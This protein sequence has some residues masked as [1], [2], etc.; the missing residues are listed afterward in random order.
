[1]RQTI[2]Q[3]LP[4]VPLVT[5]RHAKELQAM[6]DIIAELAESVF[7]A[8]DLDL[9]QGARSDRGRGGLAAEQV[10]RMFV[11][12][13]MTQLSYERLSFALEDS[14]SY[15]AFC[16]LGAADG[17]P[18]RSTL[19]D[20]IKRL[21]PETLQKIHQSVVQLG[22]DC[23]LE[24]G[25]RIGIDSTVIET[26][27]H[28]PT[29]SSLLLDGVEKLTSLLN[30]ARAFCSVHFVDHRKRAKRRALAICFAKSNE[31]RLAPYKDLLRVVEF[32]L[33]YAKDAAK[34]LMSKGARALA[35]AA[36]LAAKMEHFIELVTQVAAQTYRRVILGEQVPVSEKVVS[37][38]EPHTD[39]IVK[40]NRDT[41]YGHKAFL[42]VSH[43]GLV[44]DLHVPRGNPNDA[45]LT[46]PMVQKPCRQLRHH[47]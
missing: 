44:L 41:Y 6:S 1:M 7:R 10:V 24:D 9:R 21:K 5:H 2:L 16:L 26:H 32:T 22:I 34:K 30:Q 11:L 15:R 27:I 4:L 39:I 31:A 29:D 47:P 8:V 46:E 19:A 33:G 20:N 18:K 43:T 3:Q 38:H 13:Q 36:S 28:H 17:A 37:I 45:T 23:G 35:E 25:F 40:D 14:M 12:K 42:T